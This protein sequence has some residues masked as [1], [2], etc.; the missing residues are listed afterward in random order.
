MPSWKKLKVMIS[1]KD[2]DAV[3]RAK[4]VRELNKSIS[5]MSDPKQLSLFK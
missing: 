3:K 2:S 4:A 5:L 1:K